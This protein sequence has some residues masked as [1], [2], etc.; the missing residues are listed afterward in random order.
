MKGRV[1]YRKPGCEVEFLEG[2]VKPLI[3]E[4]AADCFVFAPFLPVRTIWN[5][6]PDDYRKGDG[7]LSQ[8]YHSWHTVTFANDE[9]SYDEAS[10]IQWVRQVQADIAR[11]QV[12]K[13]VTARNQFHRI[14]PQLMR[15]FREACRL[16]PNA[17]VYVFDSL[18]TGCW[19]GASPERLLQWRGGKG[20]TVA[21]AGTVSPGSVKEFGAKEEEEQD[22]IRIFL[23]EV[24]R[25]MNLSLH[26]WPMEITSQGNL[27]H[28]VSK[29][30]FDCPRSLLWAMVK[31]L[32]PTPAVCGYPKEAAL[33]ELE[34][35]RLHRKFYGGFLGTWSSE[36]ADLWVN[37]RCAEVFADGIN[38]YAGT[39]ITAS[40]DPQK[41]W[42]ETI[43]KLHV[44]KRLL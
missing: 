18:P 24:F 31:R 21:L 15:W 44:L 32:H 42:L 2:E 37:I 33:M 3:G 7:V 28:L 29:F 39:G 41:E 4:P 14:P 13:V 9:Q 27:K 16:Y 10:Y 43:A 40:S 23:R 8:I 30:T 38:L 11:G 26:E 5:L 34:K 12:H 1:W 36:E 17:L 19:F 35:E 25:N 22:F 20:E 6:L